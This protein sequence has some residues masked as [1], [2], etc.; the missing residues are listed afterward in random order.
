MSLQEGFAD[1]SSL[2]ATLQE[3]THSTLASTMTCKGLSAQMSAFKTEF[4]N[5]VPS[6]QPPVRPWWTAVASANWVAAMKLELRP[7]GC[8]AQPAVAAPRIMPGHYSPAATDDCFVNQVRSTNTK[9]RE[10]DKMF[11]DVKRS[12]TDQAKSLLKLTEKTNHTMQ[13]HDKVSHG[14]DLGLKVY[15]GTSLIRKRPPP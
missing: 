12:T 4:D 3:L 13:L 6:S 14:Q 9:S 2:P 11:A 15:R 7:G 8:W 5:S 10:T 1:L